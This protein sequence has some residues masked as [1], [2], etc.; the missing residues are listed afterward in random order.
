V[1]LKKELDP[2]RE[3]GGTFVSF[4]GKLIEKRKKY[5]TVS[6]SEE[7]DHSDRTFKILDDTASILTDNPD[8]KSSTSNILG[9]FNKPRAIKCIT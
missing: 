1:Q 2:K 7:V 4:L 3:V 8:E 6:N 9:D 5:T